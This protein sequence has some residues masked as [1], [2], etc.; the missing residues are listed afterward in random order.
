MNAVCLM[1]NLMLCLAAGL[2]ALPIKLVDFADWTAAMDKATLTVVRSFPETSGVQQGIATDGTYVY[3]Q[4]TSLLVKYDLEGR[5]VARS[6]KLELHHGGITYHEGRI[7]ATAS[8]CCK[9]GT[10][11]HWVYVY[12]AETLGKVAEHDIG[13]HF[14][15]CAGGIAYYD[16]HFYVA[17][18]YFDNDHG[19]Y[20]VQFDPEFKVVATYH[21]DFNCPFGIQGLDYLPSRHQFMVNSHGRAFYFIDPNFDN[22]TIVP[23]T[24]P[25][26]LQD[27]ASLDAA[28]IL[29]N[30]RDGKR[31]VF[32]S[33][34]P[35]QK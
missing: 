13:E 5:E 11:V 9:Q 19:D 4:S 15:V 27:V 34:P 3:V 25:F 28:T 14:T 32:A 2:A 33:V 6:G 12:D 35:K 21:V 16:G 10:R 7:Y 1:R 18:S 30:D 8:E 29:L 22:A 17:E 26:A 24:A 23:G 20:V 31:V